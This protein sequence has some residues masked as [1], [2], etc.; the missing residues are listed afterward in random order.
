MENLP[1]AYELYRHYMGNMYQIIAVAEH[2]ESKEQ[3]VVYQAMWGDFKIYAKPL[4]HFTGKVDKEKHPHIRQ[5]YCFEKWEPDNR[6]SASHAAREQKAAGLDNKNLWQHGDSRDLEESVGNG[7]TVSEEELGLD[8]MVLQ[9]LDADSYEER[10]NILTGIR[11]RVT[12]EMLTTM[13]IACDI[14][15][16]EGNTQERFEALKNCLVTLEKYECNRLR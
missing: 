1:K 6:L 4:S 13:A 16:S 14:E 15:V 9:F 11:H 10:L 2:A 5:V 12:D 7:E 3:L 8:P